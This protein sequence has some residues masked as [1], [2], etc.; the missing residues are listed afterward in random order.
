[1]LGID[2]QAA[3]YTWTAAAILLLLTA[4]YL[5]RTTL[6]VFIVAL[7]FAYLLTPLVDFL[8][9]ILPASRT[10]T[11][12]LI[13]AYVMVTGAVIFAGVELGSRI[14]LEAQS[15]IERVNLSGKTAEPAPVTA[16]PEIVDRILSGIQSQFRQ[17]TADIVSFLPRAG[18]K[19]LSIAGDLVWIV[20][21][22][23][24]SFFF[25]KDG[26]IM[27]EKILDLMDEGPR[28]DLVEDVVKDMNVLLAQ[29]MRALLVLSMFTLVFFSFYLSVTRVPYALL[30]AAI[31]AILEFIPMIGPFTAAVTILLVAGFSG[32]PHLL[33]ILIFLGVYR[34]F[35]DY[36]LSPHLLSEG[37]ELHPL[38]VMFGVFAGGELG[39]IPGSFLSVPIL[40]MAR[41][42]YLRLEKAHK[43]AELAR[44][45]Q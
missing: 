1:M 5:I 15:L 10:R 21:V 3:R 9:R 42:L 17:H 14:V 25:L 18:L 38:L 20:I 28:R 34:L 39:G 4:V 24:L 44:L 7:L 41:I 12:A 27:R 16:Q 13:V 29:Y 23:I 6:F 26:R 40:A 33:F 45:S 35:Q 2:R 30:L 22:P 8:D 11:P 31:A 43:A 37:M 19:A 36:V 32:Y